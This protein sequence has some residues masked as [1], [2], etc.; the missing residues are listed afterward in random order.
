MVPIKIPN[1]NVF[2]AAFQCV[3]RSDAHVAEITEAHRAI[4]GRVM[5]GRSYQAKHGFAPQC[6]A[7]C[8]DGRASRVVRIHGD[9]RIKRRVEIE[10]FPRSA[11]MLDMLT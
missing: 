6:C 2:S 7:G 10:I 4:P 11:D 5:S 9:V 1:G 8:L 3:E